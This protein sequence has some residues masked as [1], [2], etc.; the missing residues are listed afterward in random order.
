MSEL[1]KSL[2]VVALVLAGLGIVILA[3]LFL[4]HLF[5]W[6]GDSELQEL[7]KEVQALRHDANQ[8]GLVAS[9]EYAA[10]SALTRQVR[11]TRRSNTLQAQRGL[12]ESELHDLIAGAPGGAGGD[13]P[14]PPPPPP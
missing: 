4:R 1:E 12:R 10:V 11:H 3:T 13:D 6:G 14:I 2:I 8:A 5:N 9:K 7:D